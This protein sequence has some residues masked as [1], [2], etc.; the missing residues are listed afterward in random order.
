MLLVSREKSIS[1]GDSTQITK[2][3][4]AY[5]LRPRSFAR[6]RCCCTSPSSYRTPHSFV[7]DQ[8]VQYRPK[9][10]RNRASPRNE[11]RIRQRAPAS[12]G[13]SIHAAT[14]TKPNVPIS[15]NRGTGDRNRNASLLLQYD[16]QLKS[17]VTKIDV[18]VPELHVASYVG[19]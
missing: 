4:I 3:A 11:K 1:A 7:T 9:I 6:R 16:S 5:A 12:R 13:N 8:R 10:A 2:G 18:E 15:V 19:K 14:K 17:F